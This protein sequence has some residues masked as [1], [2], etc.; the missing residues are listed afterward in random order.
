MRLLCKLLLNFAL[1]SPESFRRTP[2]LY[3]GH[4]VA[5]FVTILLLVVAALTYTCEGVNAFFCPSCILLYPLCCVSVTTGQSNCV[6]WN[7][8]H[9]KTRTTGGPSNFG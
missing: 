6:V 3:R 5:A 1:L 9:H 4:K 8:I 2:H 7:G